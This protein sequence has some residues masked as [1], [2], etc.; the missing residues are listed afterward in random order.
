[1]PNGGEWHFN[2]ETIKIMQIALDD[3]WASLLPHLRAQ[4]SKTALAMTILEA[5][6]EGE[7]DPVRLRTRALTKAITRNVA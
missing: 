4:T 1:M 5:A 2:P 3:A 7:R 6:A